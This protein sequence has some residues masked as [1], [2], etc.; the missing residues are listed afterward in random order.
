MQSGMWRKTIGI[1]T[2]QLQCEDIKNFL[3][4]YSFFSHCKS[5]LQERRDVASNHKRGKSTTCVTKNTDLKPVQRRTVDTTSKLQERCGHI[6]HFAFSQARWTL[7]RNLNNFY[8]YG[9]LN[10]EEYKSN[11]GSVFHTK[12]TSYSE[13]LHIF[14][15]MIHTSSLP[16]IF[17]MRC[18]IVGDGVPKIL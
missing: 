9:Y 12:Y 2:L 10:S 15:V 5:H 8:I 13:D 4:K 1:S 7:V 17:F 3:L 14:H 11:L 6:F 18:V 16:S